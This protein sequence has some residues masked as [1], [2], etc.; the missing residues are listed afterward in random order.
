MPVYLHGS[1]HVITMHAGILECVR[2]LHCSIE[3]GPHSTGFTSA[4]KCEHAN[5][6][7]C[8]AVGWELSCPLHQYN[9][10]GFSM[11]V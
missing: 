8:N 11:T 10:S 6:V 2:I 4:C 5:P 3:Y 1:K 7:S 9:I